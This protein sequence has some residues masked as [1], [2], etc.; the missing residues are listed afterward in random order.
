MQK[1]FTVLTLEHNSVE[2]ESLRGKKKS[3]R[4][5]TAILLK[6]NHQFDHLNTMAYSV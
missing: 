2:E 3:D 5:I 4:F 6:M 1:R